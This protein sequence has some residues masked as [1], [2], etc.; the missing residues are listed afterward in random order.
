[1]EKCDIC[2]ELVSNQSNL[3]KHITNIRKK[4][5][6]KCETCG[7][8]FSQKDNLLSRRRN[9][10]SKSMEFECTVC[11]KNLVEKQTCRHIKMSVLN[12]DIAT[13][14]FPRHRTF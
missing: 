13:K 6:F 4:I 9:I 8:E 12:V 2:N 1:M 10:H 11:E 3:R 5:K 7:K 14:N